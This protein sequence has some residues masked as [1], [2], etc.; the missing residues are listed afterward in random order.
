[1]RYERLLTLVRVHAHAPITRSPRGR[2]AR[3]GGCPAAVRAGPGSGSDA[4][5]RLGSLDARTHAAATAGA[6]DAAEDC[7]EEDD[8]DGDA[9][10]DDDALVVF[11]PVADFLSEVG[12]SATTLQS[13]CQT[14]R[15]G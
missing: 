15:E 13:Y 4:A 8:A 11:D 5:G 3:K 2:H 12:T 1:M 10:A 9:D 6:R 14:K 7:E